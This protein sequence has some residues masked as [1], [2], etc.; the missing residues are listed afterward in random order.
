M[1]FELPWDDS[2][3]RMLSGLAGAF[4]VGKLLEGTLA[5]VSP[6][7]PITIVSGAVLI[8]VVCAAAVLR[9]ARQTAA[10]DTVR[11][12]RDE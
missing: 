12:L 7:D 11:M 1:I 10:I 6:T 2:V 9:P 8:L 4:A 3:E 5:Q